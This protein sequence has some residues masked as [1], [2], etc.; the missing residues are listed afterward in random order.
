MILEGFSF[1]ISELLSLSDTQRAS[2]QYGGITKLGEST[3]MIEIHSL[4]DELL[5]AP[6]VWGKYKVGFPATYFFVFDFL[7]LDT[8]VP[9][10][11][12]F[13]ARL[14][15]FHCRSKSVSDVFGFKI[16]T[17]SVKL[18]HIVALGKSWATS[19]GKLLRN[20][21]KL[22]REVKEL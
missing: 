15:E 2:E 22:D 19:F 12:K 3:L 1:S 9:D 10:P 17:C 14:E 18:P 20:V 4:I 8:S 6:Q 13:V 7:D 5:S 11:V 16:T 21:L